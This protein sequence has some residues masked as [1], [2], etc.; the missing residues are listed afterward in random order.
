MPLNQTKL[1]IQDLIRLESRGKGMAFLA[2]RRK[3]YRDYRR[4]YKEEK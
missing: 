1:V 3:E 2:K 4:R